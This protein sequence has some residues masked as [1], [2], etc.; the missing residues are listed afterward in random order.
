MFSFFHTVDPSK[1]IDTFRR[2]II[3]IS[4]FDKNNLDRYVVKFY[5]Q[6]S[7]CPDLELVM[8]GKNTVGDLGIC[9]GKWGGEKIRVCFEWVPPKKPQLQVPVRRSARG[10]TNKTKEKIAEEVKQQERA[11][12]ADRAQKKQRR[13][14]ARHQQGK[15]RVKRRSRC[16]E[17]GSAC[18]MEK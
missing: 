7:D 2:D 15:A 17:W 3:N 13:I 6:R 18:T 4:G 10:S 9:T 16:W 14:S 5:L 11:L 1:P 8:D 12:R